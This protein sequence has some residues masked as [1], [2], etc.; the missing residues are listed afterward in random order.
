[1]VRGVYDSGMKS[2]LISACLALLPIS[3]M[4]L[5]AAPR[6]TT[7]NQHPTSPLSAGP[8]CSGGW[9][10]NMTLSLLQNAGITASRKID[11]SKTTTTRIASQRIGRDLFHQVY[12]V[13]YT[14]QSGRKIEAIAVHDASNEECS[15]TGVELYVVSQHLSSE[16]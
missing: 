4:G 3:V 5:S 1:M 11:F 7:Q 6:K 14:E 2:L 10:T 16:N 13:V 12:D 15:M 9:P 8:D